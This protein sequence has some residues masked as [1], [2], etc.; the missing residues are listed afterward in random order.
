MYPKTIRMACSHLLIMYKV[1]QIFGMIFLFLNGL[2]LFWARTGSTKGFF[3]CLCSGTVAVLWTVWSWALNQG[4]LE[5]KPA[6]QLGVFFFFNGI[7]YM[8]E[9]PINIKRLRQME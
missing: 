7:V 4:L 5:A 9:N 3:F 2:V 6:F 1:V 8:V